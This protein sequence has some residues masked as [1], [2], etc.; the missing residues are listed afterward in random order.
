MSARARWFA[1]SLLLAPLLASALDFPA[2]GTAFGWRQAGGV[3]RFVS[4]NLYGHIDGGAELFLEYGFT[5]LLVQKYACGDREIDVEAYRM[6]SP[7]AAVGIYLA[8]RG[9]EGK[10]I[11]GLPGWSG[12]DR[13]QLT[14]RRGDLYLQVNAFEGKAEDFPAMVALA[15]AVLAQ[16][17][18]A[19]PDPEL[20]ALLPSAGQQPGSRLL[21][22]GEYG[23]QAIFT[24]GEGDML[25]QHG[26]VYGAAADYGGEGIPPRTE[27]AVRYPGE[28]AA[29]AAFAA[30][31]ARLDPELK[32]LEKGEAALVFS[33]YSGK[34][35]RVS[36]DGAVLRAVLHL[37]ARPAL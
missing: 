2:D 18:D 30:L 32:T 15:K 10:T 22:A 31:V 37:A 25:S 7:A 29:R 21:F 19:E 33:D 20:W 8:R 12:G 5:E 13:S 11:E 3:R 17:P 14:A 6:S 36:R 16:V 35:G 27:L 24:F 1:W 23:L 4:S 28:D 34:F 26:E 9:L